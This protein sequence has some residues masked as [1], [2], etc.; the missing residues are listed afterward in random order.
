MSYQPFLYQTIE[1]G[2][3]R[4][5]KAMPQKDMNSTGDSGFSQS[6][7]QYVRSQNV[8]NNKK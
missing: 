7:E 2:I 8:V 5:A 6:R 3:L 4:V 1:N